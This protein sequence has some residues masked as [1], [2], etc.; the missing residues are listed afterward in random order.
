MKPMI[1]HPEESDQKANKY[2]DKVNRE[3][4]LA[5]I[6]GLLLFVGLFTLLIL[7]GAF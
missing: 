6:A 3:P 4:W 2:L 5:I 7:V 1:W